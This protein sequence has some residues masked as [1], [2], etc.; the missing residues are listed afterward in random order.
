MDDA[1]KIRA[2]E[3]YMQHQQKRIKELCDAVDT[4][5]DP[6]I[7]AQEILYEFILKHHGYKV[8]YELGEAMDKAWAPEFDGKNY[9]FAQCIEIEYEHRK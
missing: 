3:L 5:N 2:Y 9:G 8:L 1:L 6:Y 7:K 4:A